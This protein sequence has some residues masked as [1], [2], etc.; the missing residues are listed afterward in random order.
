MIGSIVCTSP[1]VKVGTV[2]RGRCG[3]QRKAAELTHQLTDG[4]RCCNPDEAALS[5]LALGPR[6]KSAGGD[7]VAGV[8]A[9]R[10]CKSV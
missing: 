6:L 3:L 10:C 1:A 4:L 9:T 7:L 2:D 8:L 5:R